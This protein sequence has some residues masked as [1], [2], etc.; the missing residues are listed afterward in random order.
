M[1]KLS[2]YHIMKTLR[3]L[4]FAFLILLFFEKM[5]SQSICVSP[6]CPSGGLASAEC[7]ENACVPCALTDFE[8]F[9]GSTIIGSFCDVPGSFCGSIENA[10]WFAFIAA[11]PLI[12]F[13]IETS[14][15]AGT[16]NGGG[17][18]AQIFSS[19]DCDNFTEVSNCWSVGS[20]SDGSVLAQGLTVG[21]RYFLMIDGWA[22]DLCDFTLHVVQGLG[23]SNPVEVGE[24]TISG[25]NLVPA[26]CAQPVEYAA[27]AEG[28]AFYNWE[29][30]PQGAGLI[31][32]QA[33]AANV[34]IQWIAPAGA[35]LCVT[36]SN[37]C[38]S[39]ETACMDIFSNPAPQGAFACAD[40]Q[41]LCGGLACLSGTLPAV[42]IPASFPGCI[43]SALNNPDWFAFIAGSTTIVLTVT[44]SDCVPGP[45]GNSGMQGAIYAGSCTGP[46]IASQCACTTQ[47]FTLGAANFIP[48]TTYYLLFDGCAGVVCDYEIEVVTGSTASVEPALTNLDASGEV[49]CVGA[50][51]QYEGDGPN[52]DEAIFAWSITPPI[53]IFLSGQNAALAEIQWTQTGE[54][55]VCLDIANGCGGASQICKTATVISNQSLSVAG[56]TQVC[57]GAA[58]TYQAVPG[59]CP[60]FQFAWQVTGPGVLQTPADAASAE[61]LWTT[62]GTGNVCL[63]AT[64]TSGNV[65]QDCQ[66]V[67]IKTE[68]L[69]VI[70]S[71]DP[72]VQ[73][74]WMTVC[75]GD[76][77]HLTGGA[78]SGG[79]PVTDETGFAW[80]WFFDNGMAAHQKSVS[81]LYQEAGCYQLE[82][83]MDSPGGSCPDTA[84]VLQ[85]VRV[86]STPPPLLS[87]NT[88]FG[89]CAGDESVLTATPVNQTIFCNPVSLTSEPN[90]S[91]PEVGAITDVIAF[92][93]YAN[94]QTLSGA[95]DISEIC[96]NMEHSWSGDIQIVLICPNGQ[97]AVLSTLDL[98]PENFGIPVT[99][100]EF[101]PVPGT[102][103]DYCF[104]SDPNAQTLQ[105]FN[106]QNPGLDFSAGNYQPATSLDALIGCPFNGDWQLSIEDFVGGDNG[107][108]FDWSISFETGSVQSVNDTFS[109]TTSVAWQ[110]HPDIVSFSGNSVTVAPEGPTTFELVVTDNFGCSAGLEVPVEVFNENSL[111]CLPCS[112]FVAD[113]GEPVAA[114]CNTPFPIVLTGSAN[115]SGEFIDFEWT[116]NGAVVSSVPQFFV[117]DVG[118]FELTVTNHVSG[119]TATDVVTVG[120]GISPVA[121]AGNTQFLPCPEN[122]TVTLGGSG[123]T[124]GGNFVFTWVLQGGG[125]GVLSTEPTA[126]VDEPG[127]Y[128]FVVTDSVSGCSN[129]DNVQVFAPDMPNFQ[130]FTT[131]DSCGASA[132]T[133]DVFYP[134]SLQNVSFLWSNGDATPNVEGLAFGDYE[135]QVSYNPGCV[136][137]LDVEVD[138]VACFLGAGELEGVA[139]FALSPNPTGGRFLVDL[140]LKSNQALQLDLLDVSGRALKNLLPK[141]MLSAGA[142]SFPLDVPDL[143]DGT[144]LVLLSSEGGSAVRKMVVSR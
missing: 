130:L 77:L 131:P 83:R 92:S 28:A 41:L 56:E 119:C 57:S 140:K 66:Q 58:V 109:L 120:T 118:V 21:H 78:V 5:A 82:L 73:G 96:L 2:S 3:F 42:N 112:E 36:P 114:D 44:P 122:G 89:I 127:T 7:A 40:A 94:G 48:G 81:V 124:T 65:V 70:V 1:S 133:A 102:G 52:F 144:Y 134:V 30:V 135:V 79:V 104:S 129:L 117:F 14:N 90:V 91:I 72:A 105:Q 121:D 132:G 80:H 75:L 32:G 43:S 111:A 45:G 13:F 74:D 61:V 55:Q 86:I 26:Q 47:A 107:W 136:V 9:S 62:A 63:T 100:D 24:A 137:T 126:V 38:D 8:G 123:T 125:G 22:G 50:S 87:T 60:G 31:V 37:Y 64:G 108:L 49:F 99:G 4:P 33:Q 128:F 54:A 17:I 142:H 19:D 106:S 51:G 25:Q 39:G 71:S 12:E 18:Q 103:F 85:K 95:D 97:Q 101:Q 115:V 53:G 6:A 138:S 35:Q 139:E 11:E 67:E 59:D 116:S 16:P 20:M 68:Y 69:P 23:N 76:S 143:T 46:M 93:G 29:I 113:A 27:F 15:C 10:Q 141:Q 88:E 84:V 34:Q 98:G 110:P